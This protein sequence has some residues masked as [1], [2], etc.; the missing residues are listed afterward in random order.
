VIQQFLQVLFLLVEYCEVGYYWSGRFEIFEVI[1][2]VTCIS[3]FMVPQA[4]SNSLKNIFV[5]IFFLKKRKVKEKY[6]VAI[7]YCSEFF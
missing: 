4:F 1:Y 2:G 6:F 3:V 7:Y 5:V